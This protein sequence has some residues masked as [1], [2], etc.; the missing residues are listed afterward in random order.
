MNLLA[1]I[2]RFLYRSLVVVMVVVYI[3]APLH[4]PLLDVAHVVSHQLESIVKGHAAHSH[5]HSHSFQYGGHP[6]EHQAKSHSH[7]LISFFAELLNDSDGDK[8]KRDFIFQHTIDK[9]I[10]AQA[11]IHTKNVL[12]IDFLPVWSLHMVFNSSPL[13]VITPPP[14]LL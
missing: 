11:Y 4:N 13:E 8:N 7:K 6:H 2:K 12:I 1:N 10:V 3:F 14:K 9:H 5:S